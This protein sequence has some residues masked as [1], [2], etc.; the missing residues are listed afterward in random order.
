MVPFNY[1][2]LVE[3]ISFVIKK[4]SQ[5]DGT[6]RWTPRKEKFMP[7]QHMSNSISANAVAIRK[8]AC[9]LIGYCVHRPDLCLPKIEQ[10]PVI[11]DRTDRDA[12]TPSAN[13][14]LQWTKNIA[15]LSWH[16]NSVASLFREQ[17]SFRHF[18]SCAHGM[19]C[20]AIYTELARGGLVSV[21]IAVAATECFELQNSCRHCFAAYLGMF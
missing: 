14:Y 3:F 9:S 12:H 7:L 5:I 20:T 6:A 4:T 10:Q 18:C 17:L 1:A 21:G 13:F 2:P 15:H 19:G 16:K 8:R 11:A